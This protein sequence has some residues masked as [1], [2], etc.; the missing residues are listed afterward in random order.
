[1]DLILL[2]K[3]LGASLAISLSGIGSGLSE[4][5][6]AGKASEAIARQPK[7]S[8]D[9]LRFMLIT[10]A[11]TET[12]AIF[13]LLIAIMLLFMMP[14]DGSLCA[15]AAYC[16]AG[17]CMGLGA[18]GAGMGAGING[19]QACESV[20]RSP[21]YSTNITLITLIGQAISQTGTI[22]ALVISLILLFHAPGTETILPSVIAA[23]FAAGL[24]MGIGSIGAGLGSGIGAGGAS[25]SIGR[26]PGQSTTVLLTMLVGQ[27][28]S[29]TGCIFALVISLLL[30]FVTPQ[31][32]N[33]AIIGAVLGA[34][35][36]SG[37]GGIGAGVGSGYATSKASWETAKNPK[38]AGLIMRTMLL[39]QAVEHAGCIYSLLIAFILL[40]G[41]NQ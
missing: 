5:Y 39:G 3:F 35:L 19:G 28:I 30:C 2:S 41:Q 31:G 25:R 14:A 34:A 36:S 38:Y 7:A 4:G 29:Q 11:I 1:M 13:G 40:M 16:G 20:G 10:Q 27:A 24:C 37:F 23:F 33:L 15:V 21:K 22:F 32:T 26:Y 17:I 9:V 18:I 12:T 8:S 6:I